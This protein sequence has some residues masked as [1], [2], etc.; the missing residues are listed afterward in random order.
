[1]RFGGRKF[2]AR[3]AELMPADDA[4][5]T[6]VGVGML[7]LRQAMAIVR[8]GG[9]PL[10]AGVSWGVCSIGM[11]L[12]NK[13]AVEKTGAPLG[14]V[15]LQM[16]ATSLLALSQYK[17]LHFGKGTRLWAMTVPP[18]FMCMMGSSMLAL[19]YVSV[20][21]F[22]VVRNLGPL[23]TLCV[24]VALHRPDNLGCN[25]R[26]VGATVAIAAGVYMYE[27]HDIRWN[28]SGFF[29]LIANLGF[30]VRRAPCR[31]CGS[32]RQPCGWVASAAA[33]A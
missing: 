13:R 32:C 28:Q 17:T 12:L 14:V 20:G 21:A 33:P 24:E 8:T 18:L 27:A 31:P 29:F 23:V 26:T 4:E 19:K 5:G 16:L 9:E 30:A 6:R 10:A 1:M 2:N 3:F 7:L 15:A 22:V 11:T 25:P